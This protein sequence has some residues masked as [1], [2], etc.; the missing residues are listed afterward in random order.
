MAEV[1]EAWTA[2][3]EKLTRLAFG[4]RSERL[5]AVDLRQL[6]LFNEAE[7]DAPKAPDHEL[8][9]PQKGRGRQGG[10]RRRPPKE[11]ERI[12]RL[13][14]VPLADRLCPCCGNSRPKIG[15]DRSEELEIIPAKALVVVHVR[16]KYGPCS[17][18]GFDDEEDQAVIQE[19]AP[20]KIAPGSIF[21]NRT[22]AHLL[23]AKYVDGVPFYRQEK[24]AR[25]MGVDIE[26]SVM[27]RLAIRTSDRLKRLLELMLGDLRDSPVVRMDET[28]IQVLKEVGRSPSSESRMWV[29]MGYCEAGEIIYFHYASSRSGTVAEGILGSAWRGYLQTDGYSGYTALGERKGIEHVGCWAH[30]RRNFYELYVLQ[31]KQGPTLEILDFIKRLYTIEADLRARGEHQEIDLQWFMAE[32]TAKAQ[33]AFTDIFA[34]LT[35]QHARVAP[36]GPMGKAIGYA[37]GQFDRAVRYI[38]HPL[39]TPDTNLIENAIRPFVIGRKAWMFADTPAGATASAALYSLVETAKTNDHEPY[40]YL[41]HLFEMVP[42]AENDE[43]LSLLLPYRLD[44][45]AY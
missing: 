38:E 35:D 11:L 44:P 2:K 19:R 14:D 28:P 34:W 10:G 36:Q 33:A 15:E 26:R 42:R 43:A 17:C 22:I 9:L 18:D 45:T 20:A 5:H 25:R 31:G 37:L 32:R 4:R 1:I 16:P 21:S 27:A 30:I 41:C 39:L 23:A 7:Q 6:G 12:E 3:Y 29:T 8:R 24:I 40:R 13:H